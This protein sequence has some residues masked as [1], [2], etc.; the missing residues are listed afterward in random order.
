SAADA[1]RFTSTG[2]Y[3]G[4]K[5]AGSQFAGRSTIVRLP[6]DGG[7]VPEGE[8]PAQKIARLR[9]MADKQKMLRNEMSTFDKVIL[10]GRV[11]ADRAHRFTVYCLLGL[12]GMAVVLGAVSIVDMAI[13][14]RQKRLEYDQ[15]NKLAYQTALHNAIAAKE[16]GVASEEALELIRHDAEV[17]A[18]E[19]E[20]Q[21][22]PSLWAR[23]KMRLFGNL[24]KEE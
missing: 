12:G 22:Q 10:R 16:A 6:E 19:K 23:T 7:K 18:A 3:A 8:T 2:P 24:R 13:Y 21:E 15:A 14:S 5:F 4:S 9:A 17:A 20:F 11:W 1:T